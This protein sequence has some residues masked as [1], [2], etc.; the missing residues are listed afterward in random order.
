MTE[1]VRCGMCQK[2]RQP[3]FIEK[4]GE[5]CLFCEVKRSKG[6]PFWQK[7]HKQYTLVDEEGRI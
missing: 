2:L 5:L 6:R 4:K 7:P 1:L 3:Y